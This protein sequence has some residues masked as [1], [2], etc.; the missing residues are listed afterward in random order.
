L[1]DH[2][3]ETWSYPNDGNNSGEND[4]RIIEL[5]NGRNL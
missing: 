3:L 4:R 1:E 5:K 2:V